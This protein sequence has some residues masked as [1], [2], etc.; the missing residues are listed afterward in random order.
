MYVYISNIL[1]HN[2]ASFI[3]AIEILV[4]LIIDYLKM[5]QKSNLHDLM[6]VR[7]TTR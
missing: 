5:Y 7:Y 6:I 4:Y 3:L 2:L 1:V